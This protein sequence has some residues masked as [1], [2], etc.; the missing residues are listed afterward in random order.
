MNL[1][2]S[3]PSGCAPSLYDKL[4]HEL[5]LRDSWS[6]GNKVRRRLLSCREKYR[7]KCREKYT[8][9]CGFCFSHSF[10]AVLCSLAA[11]FSLP[12]DHSGH[13][14]S[15]WTCPSISSVW[16]FS[17]R[18]A[19]ST[20]PLAMFLFSSPGCVR[21]HLQILAQVSTPAPTPRKCSP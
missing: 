14:S 5:E 1:D 16:V 2:L 8:L 4:F 3:N 17:F 10:C 21:W 9:P 6:R 18:T 11:N 20:F 7:V 15:N 12:A 13:S 19:K